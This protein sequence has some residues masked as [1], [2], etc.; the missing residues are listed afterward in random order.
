MWLYR[1]DVT[2]YQVFSSVLADNLSTSF[3]N[4]ALLKCGF[5][6]S[7]KTRKPEFGLFVL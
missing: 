3:E 4:S 1:G 7:E 5:D 6:P 2:V